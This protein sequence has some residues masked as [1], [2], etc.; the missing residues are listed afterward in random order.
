ME[1]KRKVEVPGE[2][3][4]PAT[5]GHLRTKEKPATGAGSIISI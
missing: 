1:F 5:I 4:G 3:A 2:D